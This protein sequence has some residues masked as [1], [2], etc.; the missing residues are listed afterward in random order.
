MSA[1]RL[2]AVALCTLLW[3]ACLRIGEPAPD[4]A[5]VAWAAYPETVLVNQVFSFEF[6][7]PVALDTCGRLDTAIVAVGEDGIELSARRS[8]FDALCSGERV[9]F[10]EARPLSI[11]TVGTYPVRTADG[12]D[13]GTL[14]AVDSGTFSAMRAVGVGTLREAAGCTIFGPGWASNQRPFALRELPADAASLA[15]TDTLVRVEGTLAGYALCGSF[16]SR[17]SIRVREARSLGRTGPSWYAEDD[18]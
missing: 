10:Y 14:V 4:D 15:D 7:G 9:S 13:L 11:E 6:A 16:G 12:L 3:G 8:L 2:A 5:R 17:P 1:S 18:T